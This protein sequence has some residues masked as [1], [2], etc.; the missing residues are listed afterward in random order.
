[1]IIK[2]KTELIRTKSKEKLKVSHL[3][4]GKKPR[5]ISN[6]KMVGSASVKAFKPVQDA[7]HT[8]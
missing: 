4:D 7:R 6:A 2:R 5:K 8:K 3:V 1:M